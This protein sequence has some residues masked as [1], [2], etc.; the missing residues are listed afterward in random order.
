[1]PGAAAALGVSVDAG[2]APDALSRVTLGERSAH[3]LRPSFRR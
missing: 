1:M 3:P 2:P